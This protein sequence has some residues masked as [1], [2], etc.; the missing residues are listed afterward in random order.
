[1]PNQIA[2]TFP[3]PARPVHSKYGG[4]KDM[5]V[6]RRGKGQRQNEL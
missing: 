4:I 6:N 1:M 3:D 5:T 2:D